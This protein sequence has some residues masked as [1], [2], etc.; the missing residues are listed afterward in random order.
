MLQSD[1][2]LEVLSK[3]FEVAEGNAWSG[4]ASDGEPKKD[5]PIFDLELI[6]VHYKRAVCT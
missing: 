6:P 4:S 2:W 3:E 5:T 1:P